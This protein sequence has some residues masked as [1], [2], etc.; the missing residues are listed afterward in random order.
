M[1]NR[2]TILNFDKC[3]SRASNV[4]EVEY[5]VIEFNLSMVAANA[6]I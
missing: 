3:A 1:I 5:A 4:F 6:F 2:L